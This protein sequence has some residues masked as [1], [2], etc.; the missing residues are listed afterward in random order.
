MT[1]ITNTP[2]FS[3]DIFVGTGNEYDIYTLNRIAVNKDTTTNSLDVNGN[4]NTTSK[5]R[6]NGNA[7]VPSG[8]IAIWS[9]IISTIPLGWTL[10]DGSNGTPDLR[11]RFIIGASSDSSAMSMTTISGSPTKTG[12]SKDTI[13]PAHTH[14]GVT[15]TTGSHTHTTDFIDYWGD[16]GGWINGGGNNGLDVSTLTDPAGSHTHTSTTSTDGNATSG[17]NANLPPYFALAYIMKL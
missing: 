13:L 2:N 8:M 1:S 12:G 7:L 14:T 4:V 9:G 3:N 6:Q 16:Y 10:C 17:T 5:I 11:N 15:N